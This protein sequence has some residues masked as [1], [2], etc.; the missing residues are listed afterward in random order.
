MDLN[1]MLQRA[2][3]YHNLINPDDALG[4]LVKE[5]IGNDELDENE[6]DFIAAAGC[7]NL[8]KQSNQQS[9]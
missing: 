9:E 7:S 8:V 1:Q 4:S 6:L 5:I 2:A 3:N